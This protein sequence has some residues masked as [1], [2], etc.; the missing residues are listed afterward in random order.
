MY[1]PSKCRRSTSIGFSHTFYPPFQNASSSNAAGQCHCALS[2]SSAHRSRP[3]SVSLYWPGIR[4]SQNDVPY[5]LLRVNNLFGSLR[6]LVAFHI[7]T[8]RYVGACM[9]STHR[10]DDRTHFGRSSSVPG[11]GNRGQTAECSSDHVIISREAARNIVENSSKKQQQKNGIRVQNTLL[12]QSAC[13]EL[14]DQ[15][16]CLFLK[17][18]ALCVEMLCNMRGLRLKRCN[19]EDE[20]F[21]LVISIHRKTQRT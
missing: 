15:N 13:L 3:A 1:I 19:L 20:R 8:C 4:Y 10:L 21:L 14:S 17:S 9:D 12:A 11:H 6:S 18:D 5:L 7:D 2:A 16:V